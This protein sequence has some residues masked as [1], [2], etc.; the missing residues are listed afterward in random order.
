MGS[1]T[2]R[3]VV[4]MLRHTTATIILEEDGDLRTDQELLGHAQITTTQKYT[5]ILSQRKKKA[6]DALPY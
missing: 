3:N 5:H 2:F 1:Y 4:H 6:V